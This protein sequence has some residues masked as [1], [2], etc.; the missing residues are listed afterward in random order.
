[1]WVLSPKHSVSCPYREFA[2]QQTHKQQNNDID[3]LSAKLTSPIQVEVRFAASIVT[4]LLG[5]G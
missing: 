1:M 4:L 2:T 3:R 5:D